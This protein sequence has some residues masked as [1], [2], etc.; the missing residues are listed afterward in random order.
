MRASF[1]LVPAPKLTG[2]AADAWANETVAG[3]GRLG[4]LWWQVTMVSSGITKRDDTKGLELAR[5]HAAGHFILR[6]AGTAC[7][8]LHVSEFGGKTGLHSSLLPPEIRQH[9]HCRSGG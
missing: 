4:L 2:G 5:E 8:A 6:A 7:S 1:T 3:L 9:A